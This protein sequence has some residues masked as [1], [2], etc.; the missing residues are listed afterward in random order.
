MTRRVFRPGRVYSKVKPP[1]RNLFFESNTVLKTFSLSKNFSGY[2]YSVAQNPGQIQN[3]LPYP[4][5]R[6]F[7][8]Q[9]LG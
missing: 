6:R 2:F 3:D 7:Y 1:T 5:Q 8:A 9:S 4:S